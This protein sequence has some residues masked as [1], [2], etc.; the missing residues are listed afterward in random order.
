MTFSDAIYGKAPRYVS[1]ER[2]T[3]MLG[4]EYKLL[5]ERL[6]EKRAD[7]HLFLRVRRHGRHGQRQER[8]GPAVT[9]GWASVSRPSPARNRATSSSTSRTLDKKNVLQQ[10][11]LG[12]VGTN[13]IYGAFYYRDEPEKFIQSLADNLGRTAS[14]STC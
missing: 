2:L 1:R 7:R 5:V 8:R 9:A 3:T 13:L 14:R 11:A 4:H 12:I 6:A 10:E